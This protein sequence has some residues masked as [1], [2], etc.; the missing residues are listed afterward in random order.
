MIIYVSDGKRDQPYD[1]QSN[2]RL[3]DMKKQ[4]MVDEQENGDNDVD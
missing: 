2:T 3:S 1:I 4:I